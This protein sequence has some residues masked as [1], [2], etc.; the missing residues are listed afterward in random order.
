MDI[1]GEEILEESFWR[2]LLYSQLVEVVTT[3]TSNN[4]ESVKLFF[5]GKAV[6]SER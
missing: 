1:L 2:P 6:R 4:I 5:T 3:S